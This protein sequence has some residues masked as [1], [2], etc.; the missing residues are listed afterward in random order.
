MSAWLAER[1]SWR[2]WQ[3]DLK[4]REHPGTGAGCG[5]C[6]GLAPQ[7]MRCEPMPSPGSTCEGT[8]GDTLL[9][10]H[11]RTRRISQKDAV[12]NMQTFS[13]G[14]DGRSIFRYRFHSQR[15]FP[16]NCTIA[17]SSKTTFSPFLKE[18]DWVER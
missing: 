16:C 11:P 1:G 18:E 4:V 10:L 12:T 9:L 3:Q 7:G 13:R 14:K 8:A 2:G 6:L 17:C 15:H 5:G